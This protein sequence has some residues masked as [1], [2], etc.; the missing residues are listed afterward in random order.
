MQAQPGTM[1]SSST[2]SPASMNASTTDSA[3]GAGGVGTGGVFVRG[4]GT[5]GPTVSSG[6]SPFSNYHPTAGRFGTADPMHAFGGGGLGF[7]NGFGG[8]EDPFPQRLPSGTYTRTYDHSA[9]TS[10]TNLGVSRSALAR[11]QAMEGLQQHSEDV[12][13][14]VLFQVLEHLAG[15]FMMLRVVAG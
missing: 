15:T 7:G 6:Q 8:F 9:V 2:G 11:L 1:D 13:L 12:G 10:P 3:L 4:P 5:I 14:R